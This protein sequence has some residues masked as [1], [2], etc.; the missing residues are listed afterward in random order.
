MFNQVSA[1]ASTSAL[2]IGQGSAAY[3]INVGSLLPLPEPFSA[4]SLLG[5]LPIQNTSFIGRVDQLA[6]I[7]RSLNQAQQVVVTQSV[8]GLGGVGK[9][10]LVTEYVHQSIA[11]NKYAFIAWLDGTQPEHAYRSLGECLGLVFQPTDVDMQDIIAKV[12]QRLIA[13]YPSLLLVWDDAKDEAQIHPY[14]AS[15][16]RLKAHCLITSRAQNW[17]EDTSL[18]M[19]RLDVFSEAEA[20]IF[21]HQRFTTSVGLY[22]EVAAKN[23]ANTVGYLPL[24]LAQAAAYILRQRQM[25]RRTYAINDYLSA[26]TEAQTNTKKEFYDTALSLQDNY[27]NKI[28][29]TTWY[30]SIEALK[31]ENPQAVNLIEQC[32]YLDEHK[33]HDELLSLLNDSPEDEVRRSI[34]ALLA[35]SLVGRL[36]DT[37]LPAIKMHKIL[38]KV[39]RQHLQDEA[40]SSSSI[41]LILPELENATQEKG[42][43]PEALIIRRY[44]TDKANQWQWSQREEAFKFVPHSP[45]IALADLAAALAQKESPATALCK[46]DIPLVHHTHYHQKIALLLNQLDKAFHYDEKHMEQLHAVHGL[47]ASHIKAVCHHAFTAEIGEPNAA[48]LLFRL[49]ELTHDLT[50]TKEMQ[51]IFL[52]ILPYYESFYNNHPWL[53]RVLN[54]LAT[55][56]GAL[57]KP[58]VQKSLWQR[59]LVIE[60]GYY[61]ADHVE[62]ACTLNNLAN[63]YGDLGNHQEKKCLLQRALV[64]KERYYGAEHV[65]VASTLN[66]LANAYGNL[67]NHQEKK[68]LLQ[69]ALVIKEC[70]Y[71]AEHVEV[72]S[73]LNNLANAY[74]E[75]G[76]PKEQQRLLQ[77]ALVIFERD[78]GAD[79][80]EVASTLNN[81]ATA[82]GDLGDPKEQ[83]R[84]LQRTLVIQERYY[85]AEHVEIACTL[86]NLA[87]AYGA[88]GDPKEQRRLLQRAL[89]IEESYY[90]PDHVEVASTLG[91]LAN[92]Y[93]D[94]DEFPSA[95][96]CCQ[97]ALRIKQ[98]FFEETHPEVGTIFFILATLYFKQKKFYL[99]LP[100]LKQVHA[101]FSNHSNCGPTHPYTLKAIEILEELAPHISSLEEEVRQCKL[102]QHKGDEAFQDKD[103]STAIR[104]WQIAL[105]FVTA[106][107]FLSLTNKLDAILLHEQLGEA[108]CEQGDFDNAVA[109]FTQAQ[110][111]LTYLTMQKSDDYLRMANKKSV[112]E[113]KVAANQAHQ[114]G[115]TYYK[116]GNWAQAI[117]AFQESLEKNEFFFGEEVHADLASSHWCLSSCYLQQADY[118]QALGHVEKAYILGR[119][120][121]GE[122]AELNQKTKERL[123]L[124]REKA[125]NSPP[126]TAARTLTPQ[127]PYNTL[128]VYAETTAV[129]PTPGNIRSNNNEGIGVAMTSVVPHHGFAPAMAGATTPEKIT[130]SRHVIY[131]PS[132]QAAPPTPSKEGFR[133]LPI[134]SGALF[135]PLDFSSHSSVRSH[136]SAIEVDKNPQLPAVSRMGRVLLRS[137]TGNM[138][139]SHSTKGGGDCAFHA[140]LG[141]WNTATGKFETDN[142]VEKRDRVAAAIRICRD[143]SILFPL[144][145]DAIRELIMSTQALNGVSL[146]L[147]RNAY[148]RHVAEC[149]RRTAELRTA[150]K[151]ELS[152]H[153]EMKQRINQYIEQ[154]IENKKLDERRADQLRLNLYAQFCTYEAEH[155][156]SDEAS[157]SN[158]IKTTSFKVLYDAYKTPAL[159]F[160]WNKRC[161]DLAV[162]SEYA[163][164][165]SQGGQYLLP[166]ELHIIAHVFDI[167]IVYYPYHTANPEDINPGSS[168]EVCVLFNGINH[169]ERVTAELW[170]SHLELK[171]T[172]E[173]ANA[174]RESA[175]L[176]Q[177]AKDCRETLVSNAP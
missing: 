9:T 172:V 166:S 134:T 39:I 151:K 42:P 128:D 124:C 82:Y 20:L 152:H 10:Q 3:N 164:F 23:L 137:S 18:T 56:Y 70:C 80:L 95:Q 135:M 173:K 69:R 126:Q 102:A 136:D 35:Y 115:V 153:P 57:G 103:Y 110:T 109:N 176:A 37:Q 139:A 65:E 144:V 1:R 24:A 142:I 54:Y 122:S 105:P 116:A 99:G 6:E 177:K 62:I 120:L 12:E 74:G 45:A 75:L 133:R 174:P 129:V 87:S 97:R 64:I 78:Y 60:E 79:H 91:N 145:I 118:K 46:L 29:W 132:T 53:G 111:Q 68:R 158:L 170:P 113:I 148:A 159:E 31:T 141:S 49:G 72:A 143:N 154:Y 156:D 147:L 86:G 19:I 77:R 16:A 48:G 76:N 14:L 125:A 100:Y 85:G 28:V 171:T 149:T 157:I 71:G 130:K 40:L 5:L 169:Y 138:A 44:L 8:M 22:D 32:A 67:G 38:Q 52:K 155:Q 43:I 4:K 163:L 26:Y 96:N 59:A 55:A 93:G 98:H 150:I 117:M 7:T 168:N 104:H 63:V 121:W 106:Q 25:Y 107:S 33:I 101:I 94:L 66:N 112:C 21:L 140:A 108:Y 2:A 58:Q 73:T 30:L 34:G 83:Q 146:Q 92:A 51:E 15:A 17:S 90:G 175:E 50:D 27:F 123:T 88:L 167:H 127:K 89:V 84:L 13:H 41:P 114:R 61:G 165:F 11:S 161:E 81:L 131:G 47:F 119:A 36:M 160:P 162:L